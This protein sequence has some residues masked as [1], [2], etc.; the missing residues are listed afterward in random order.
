MYFYNIKANSNILKVAI[1]SDGEHTRHI[2]QDEYLKGYLGGKSIQDN[3]LNNMIICYCKPNES[4]SKFFEIRLD[5]ND[6]SLLEIN[7]T[8]TQYTLKKLATPISEQDPCLY[9]LSILLEFKQNQQ[10]TPNKTDNLSDNLQILCE[11]NK[12]YIARHIPSLFNNTFLPDCIIANMEF[13]S[14]NIEEYC[15]NEQKKRGMNDEYKRFILYNCIDH[16]NP[17]RKLYTKYA[18]D[19][20]IW[21]EKYIENCYSKVEEIIA[22][23]D[24]KLDRADQDVHEYIDK[25]NKI[26]INDIILEDDSQTSPSK[27]SSSFLPTV[28]V[29]GVAATGSAV[30]ISKNASDSKNS[31]ITQ[32]GANEDNENNDE[33]PGSTVRTDQAAQGDVNL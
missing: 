8:I 30:A 22:K 18:I 25:F 12:Q 33:I 19:N 1:I 6:K 21:T 5:K 32:D 9:I 13:F 3:N 20:D 24:T 4:K 26:D 15:K 23:L 31:T 2:K 14:K 11:V 10:E 27:S 16:Y 29:L 7:N 17:L 28:I